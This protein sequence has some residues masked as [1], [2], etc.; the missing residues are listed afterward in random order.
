MLR[1]ENGT[2]LPLMLAI[3]FVVSHLLLMMAT[4][5][6]IRAIAYERTRNYMM[7][8][9]LE[10]EALARIEDFLT[11]TDEFFDFSDRWI[12][13]NNAE[14]TINMIKREDFFDFHY[15]ILY[16]GYQHLRNLSFCLE[17]GIII[18]N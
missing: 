17:K 15:Q 6:E 14:M 9:L 12:L 16:N 10:R 11:T 7:M 2:M 4:Q 18:F 5:V 8:N 3:V 13:K 1:D